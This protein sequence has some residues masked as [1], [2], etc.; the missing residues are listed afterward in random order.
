MENQNHTRDTL[1][2]FARTIEQ[3]TDTIQNI[4]RIEEEKA[5]AASLGLHDRMDGILKREQVYLLQL[6]GLEQKRLRLADAMGFKG[7][8]FR[9]ILSQAAEEQSNLLFPLFEHL[10]FQVRHLQE[11]KDNADRMIHVRLREFSQILSNTDGEGYDEAGNLISG[12]SSHFHDRY[13]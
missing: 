6:R 13:V 4:A 10:E 12:P 7:L 8:T 5:E 3:L 1:E 9:Q 2:E 11:M